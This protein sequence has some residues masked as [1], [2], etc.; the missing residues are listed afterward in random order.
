MM[1]PKRVEPRVCEILVVSEDDGVIL[2]SPPIKEVIRFSFK[3]EVPD[4]VYLPPW[5]FFGQPLS[6][7][8][9]NVLVEKNSRHRL[10]P[11]SRFVLHR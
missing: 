10:T 9:R 8:M 2:L 5:K 7:F 4:M 6:D 11:K 3:T 1:A